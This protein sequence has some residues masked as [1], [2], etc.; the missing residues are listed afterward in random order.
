MLVK[1]VIVAGMLGLLPSAAAA[2][3]PPAR[4]AGAA[5]ETVDTSALSYYASRHD[6]ARMDAELRRLR[7]LYPNWQPPADPASLPAPGG[8][9]AVQPL[10]DLFA[11]D[12]LD[13]LDAAIAARQAASP[14]FAPPPD[15]AEKLAAKRARLALLAASGRMDYGG[16]IDIAAR[17]P[18][19]VKPDDL[20]VSWTVAEAYGRAGQS[21]KALLLDQTILQATQEP[22]ARLATVRKAMASLAPGDLQT[23]LGM[24]KAGPDGRSEFAAVDLDLVRQRVGRVL[25]A[26]SPGEATP[27]DVARL[28][29]SARAGAASDA[30]LLGWLAS[31]QRS[32]ASAQAWFQLALAAGPQPAQARPEDAKVAQGAVLAFRALGR[33]DDAEALAY[34]WRDADAAMTLLY[35]DGVQADLTKPKPVAVDPD[36]LKRFSDLVAKTQSG[37]GAQALGWYAYNIGQFRPA[38]AWFGKALAWQPRDSTALGLALSLKQ[39]GDRT[40]L[41]DF[42][43]DNAATFP[44]LATVAAGRAAPAPVAAEPSRQRRP[45]RVHVA[46]GPGP[47]RAGA[48]RDRGCSAD[49]S[50]RGAGEALRSGWCLMELDRPREAAIA[51]A[52]AG[53]S[54]GTATDAAYGRAL[55]DLRARRTR[56]AVAA[57]GAGALTPAHRREVGLAALSQTAAASFDQGRYDDTLAALDQRQ[58]FT[59]EPRDLAVLRAWSAYHTGNR[60]SAHALFSELDQQLSTPETRSGLAATDRP[61]RY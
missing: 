48:V 27:G 39:S 4:P 56:G 6:T 17:S 16:V 3:A 40:A 14:D 38:Q 8:D 1:R 53:E 13:E 37:D 23:L 42:L 55:A 5:P 21:A 2:Q 24:G 9:A 52:A 51:F 59:P 35:L 44:A 32:W 49:V 34:R 25:A 45:A 20:D 28:E 58:A 18:D 12:K 19:L 57:A 10:W 26:A 41:A 11:A 7:S 33:S 15:L 29:A 54:S 47:R 61:V 46:G 36:R 50:G 30:A 60:E 43:K 22:T 31:K